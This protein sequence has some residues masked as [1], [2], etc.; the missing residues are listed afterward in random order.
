M[1]NK[2]RV[3]L[4]YV[5]ALLPVVVA[6]DVYEWV[7][8]QG[9][10]HYSDHHLQDN[11][12]ILAVNADVTYYEVEKVYDGDTILLKNGQKIRLLGVN[13]PEV[14]GRY[15]NAEQGGEEAKVWLQQCL[16]HKKVRLE[17]DVEQ[18]DKYQRT[19]AHV[20]TDD[21]LHVNLELVRQGLASVNIYPPNLKYVETLLAA[22]QAAEE[23]GLGLWGDSAYAP[24]GFQSIS[25]EDY[26]GWRRITG[27]IKALKVAAKYSYLQF[28]GQFSVRIENKSLGLFPPLNDYVGKEVEVR[29]WI[30]K[31]KDRF[32]VLVR[33]PGE[34]KILRPAG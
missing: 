18:H 22:Q 21:K 28:S 9:R 17:A 14:A 23:A 19:L 5:L 15:K 3:R 1:L 31:S 12:R 30:S 16:Q 29:G 25:K 11:A 10:H 2:N 32:T 34:L 26:Q 8:A 20:F 27:R 33:H 7:D 13:T 24:E 4:I 6:A